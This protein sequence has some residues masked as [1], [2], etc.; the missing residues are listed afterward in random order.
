MREATR[1]PADDEATATRRA[2]V[3]SLTGQIHWQR[4]KLR[5]VTVTGDRILGGLLADLASAARLL[6][7]Q[8]EPVVVLGA[9]S[10]RVSRRAGRR[11]KVRQC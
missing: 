8:L 5:D 2:D 10:V 1:R 6:A 9:V 11:G 4:E 7:K 3:A